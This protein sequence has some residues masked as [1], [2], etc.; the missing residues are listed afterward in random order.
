MWLSAFVAVTLLG[1][2]IACPDGC[3]CFPDPAVPSSISVACRWTYLPEK[4]LVP[5]GTRNLHIICSGTEPKRIS[6]GLFAEIPTLHGLRIEGCRVESFDSAVFSHLSGLRSLLL[7][8][9]AM[10]SRALILPEDT[11]DKLSKLEKLQINEA[12]IELLPS[13]MFCQMPHLMVF[14]VSSN[15]LSGSALKFDSNCLSKLIIVDLSHN[16]IASLGVADLLMFPSVRQMSLAHNHI[17]FVHEN[18]F[19]ANG[20]VQQLDFENNKVDGIPSLPDTLI[21]VNLARNLLKNVPKSVADLPK[22]VSLN[23]S[24]NEIDHKTTYSLKTLE[25]EILDLSHNKFGQM[26]TDFVRESISALVHVDLNHNTV[27][28]LHPFDLANCTKLQTLNLDS[29]RLTI[30]RD[31]VFSGLTDLST[32]SLSNNSLE[33]IESASFADLTIGEIN[34]SNNRFTEVPLGIGRLFKLRKI[35]MS[36]NRISKLFKFVF[37]KIPHLHHVDLSYNELQSVGPFVFS[38]CPHLAVLDLSHNQINS[39]IKDSFIKCPLLRRMDLSHNR[40]INYED[41]LSQAASLK[42]LNLSSNQLEILQWESLPNKLEQLDADDNR[43]TLL[44][45]AIQSKVRHASIRNNL[46]EQLSADQIPD[47]IETLDLTGNRVKVIAKGT[48]SS[49]SVVKTVKLEK[50]A[51]QSVALDSLEVTQGIYPIQISLRDNPL[52]CSC[53]LDWL[54]QQNS[55][56]SKVVISDRIE[57]RCSHA[58]NGRKISLSNVEQKDLLCNYDRVCEPGCICCQFGSCDCRSICPDGCRCFRDAQHKNNIVRCERLNE[59]QSRSFSPRDLPMSATHVVLSGLS[60]PVLK[61]HSFLGRAKLQHLHINASGL[62]DIQPMA[63]NT[64]P[65]LQLLDLSDN[66]LEKLTGEELHKTTKITHLFLN[67]NRLRFFET[68]VA[69]KLTNL[70]LVTL[71]NNLLEDISTS[72]TDSHS[73]LSVSLSG[74]PFRCDCGRRFIAPEWMSNN[75]Q[76]VVDYARVFCVEN[77]THAFR[78]N[79]TTVLSAYPPNMGDDVYTMPIDDFVREANRTI[80][81]PFP[82]GLFGPEPQSSLLMVLLLTFCILLSMGLVALAVAVVRRAHNSMSQRR[83]KAS[84]SLNCSSTTPGS[85]P[86]PIPLINY[87][88]FVSYSKKDEK[89]V[90]EQ[91]CR[92]LEEE[93]YHLCLLH[94]DGPVYNSK[95]HSISDELIAQMDASQCLI[96]VLT[97]NFLENEWKTLQIKTSH[98][99]FAKNRSKRVIAVQ[100]DGV[101]LNLL[102]EELGQVLRKSGCIGIRHHLFWNLLRSQ[103][104][105][106]SPHTLNSNTSSQIYSDLYGPVPSAI[107]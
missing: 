32:L 35:D 41:A 25:L 61:A 21:H 37:N 70:Q 5:S 79:D 71:H 56:K 91:L 83:Y 54:N 17:N 13:K 49:K 100:G 30:L 31:D 82:T 65:N 28:D 96:L 24:H 12:N 1:L 26:P 97:K 33:N 10:P 8:K 47:T 107:V 75:R 3:D 99:L 63:F 103:L 36:R 6:Q 92:P 20:L 2:S 102:D 77:V 23:L 43:I 73:L 81:V 78:Q 29:N 62:T 84:S 14:N 69:K 94:R 58:V 87:D 85:S 34:L 80:C 50:N 16:K 66:K 46:I 105:V 72:L 57:T 39:L 93:D 18:A 48:F 98:Q 106:R 45:A 38:D 67:G 52:K 90:V 19:A 53:E 27:S 42:R 40:L 89:M 51:I 11:F 64:L 101:D 60:L 104:P 4:L 44:G 74:N 55:V 88:A 7:E 86:L 95:V 76:K 68:E 22:L 15:W 59:T 9:I